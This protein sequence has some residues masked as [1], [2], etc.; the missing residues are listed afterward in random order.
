MRPTAQTLKGWAAALAIPVIEPICDKGLSTPLPNLTKRLNAGEIA[1]R[2]HPTAIL[3]YSRLTDSSTRHASR[4][5]WNGINDCRKYVKAF[6]KYGI[7]YIMMY[8]VIPII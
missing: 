8:N 4:D 6:C 5:I 3:G 7:C 2:S 1:W